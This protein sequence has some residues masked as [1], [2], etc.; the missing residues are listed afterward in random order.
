[1][2][3]YEEVFS[4]RINTPYHHDGPFAEE[5]ARYLAYL[6]ECGWARATVIGTACKLV[7]F[8]ARVNIAAKRGVT[9]AQIEA[10]A[11][12]WMKHPRH[13]FRRDIGRHKGSDKVRE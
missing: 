8:A 3:Q 7:A 4:G 6:L 13:H 9:A 1:M 5:R 10:A 11:D 2:N 12:D